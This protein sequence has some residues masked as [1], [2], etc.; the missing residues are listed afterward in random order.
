[1]SKRL[2][3]TILALAV[4]SLVVG[5]AV[6]GAQSKREFRS[7]LNGKN[8]NTTSPGKGTAKFEI[9]S[10]GKSIKYTLRATGLTGP[11]QAAHIHLGKA[12]VNGDVLIAICGGPCSLPRSGTLTAKNFNKNQTKVA[13]FAA[14]LKAIRAGRTYVNVHT[15]ANPGGE[16]RGQL[17]ADT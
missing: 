6:A 17:R 10:S 11:V 12:G 9:S 3:R 14:A 15:K 4:A 7:I 5:V 2:M 16:I 13:S 1:M 8:D